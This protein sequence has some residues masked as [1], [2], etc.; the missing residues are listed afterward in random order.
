MMWVPW[1]LIQC[2]S[3]PLCPLWL[4]QYLTC[5][6]SIEYYWIHL[7]WLASY[8]F[9]C[10]L[11]LSMKIRF[12]ICISELRLQSG[13]GSFT[14]F[15]CSFLHRMW[16]MVGTHKVFEGQGDLAPYTWRAE[17]FS[18]AS[19]FHFWA[20]WHKHHLFSTSSN[21]SAK[22]SPTQ[23]FGDGVVPLTSCM[24]CIHSW[25]PLSFAH[26]HYSLDYPRCLHVRGNMVRTVR[27]TSWIGWDITCQLKQ[28]SNPGKE[29]LL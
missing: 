24:M 7:K 27:D 2:G 17:E 5:M 20:T 28:T 15:S 25:S 21:W 18:E 10:I 6:C 22:D 29:F 11:E 1:W 26:M 8:F 13:W 23:V 12:F 4:I 14:S 16:F 9:Y 3:F 19:I